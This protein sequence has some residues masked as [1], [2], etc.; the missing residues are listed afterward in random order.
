[1]RGKG[2]GE[3]LNEGE[4]GVRKAWITGEKEWEDM[5]DGGRVKEGCR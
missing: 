2:S 1:M 3:S 5:A 4:F